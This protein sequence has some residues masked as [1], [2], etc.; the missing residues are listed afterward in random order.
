MD[1]VKFSDHVRQPGSQDIVRETPD[2][3][4]NRIHG[5]HGVTAET[6]VVARAR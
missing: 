4:S 3:Y 2:E 5:A 6:E 1:T